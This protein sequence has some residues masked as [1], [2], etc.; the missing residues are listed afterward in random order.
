MTAKTHTVGGYVAGA[1][2][3]LLLNKTGLMKE[4]ESITGL[5]ASAL[6]LYISATSAVL[7]DVDEIRSRVGRKLLLFSVPFILF[8]IAGKITGSQWFKHR[9]L[10]HY[11]ITWLI[12]S[13]AI[14]L[15]CI[16]GI[17]DGNPLIVI[18][19]KSLLFFPVGYLSHILLDLL[20]GKVKLLYPIIK[21]S[22]GINLFPY[23]SLREALLRTTLTA[24]ATHLTINLIK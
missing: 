8:R 12:T 10:T 21:K 1:G 4:P 5:I 18:I 17:T 9:G 15:P 23:N 19:A 20:S 2:T 14:A 16:A 24:L 6:M 11:L 3:L 13:T 22:I 7:S